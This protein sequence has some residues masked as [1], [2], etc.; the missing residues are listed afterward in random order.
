MGHTFK[1]DVETFILLDSCGSFHEKN[2][3]LDGHVCPHFPAFFLMS[4]PQAGIRKRFLTVND[5]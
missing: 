5:E 2:I 4:F 3:T 1:C